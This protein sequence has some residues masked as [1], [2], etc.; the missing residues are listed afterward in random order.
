AG[1]SLLLLVSLMALFFIL[2]DGEALHT[3]AMQLAEHQLG[4][5]GERFLDQLVLAVRGTVGGT[6]AVAIGE[7]VLIGAG[8]VVAG[9]PHALF[10]AL[11]PTAFP[12]LPFGAR[13]VVSGP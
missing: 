13:G 11:L 6:I 4:P 9:V 1:R 3:R 10:L 12:L 5:F 2:R 7:G 8:Y